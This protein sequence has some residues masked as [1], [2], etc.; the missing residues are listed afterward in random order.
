MVYGILVY[1][2]HILFIFFRTITAAAQQD[3]AGNE[4][5]QRET[6]N[7]AGNNKKLPFCCRRLFSE[8][9]FLVKT[10]RQPLKNEVSNFNYRVKVTK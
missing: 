7:R 9:D 5:Q 4:T 1:E 8:A 10:R 6:A 3:T 2:L